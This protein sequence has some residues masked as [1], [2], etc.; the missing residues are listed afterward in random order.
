LIRG[1]LARLGDAPAPPLAAA[2]PPFRHFRW[3]RK[4]RRG[5][6]ASLKSSPGNRVEEGEEQPRTNAP[7][8]DGGRRF[9]FVL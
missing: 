7:P 8:T 6:A 1:R 3:V 9:A 2:R 5:R 4:W